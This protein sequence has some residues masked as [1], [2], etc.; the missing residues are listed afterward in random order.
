MRIRLLLL[1]LLAL[2]L[3]LRGLA[4]SGWLA[5]PHAQQAATS[6]AHEHAD[7]V[8]HAAPAADAAEPDDA[9]PAAPSCNACSPCCA[10]AL[11]LGEQV[12]PAAPKPSPQRSHFEP[13]AP[14]APLNKPFERPP[15]S[16]L[17]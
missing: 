14:P 17:A 7:H 2:A 16:F 8:H 4:A 13:Q 1:M 6:T 12:P 3:P 15:R 11:P 5:C 9:R 10:A